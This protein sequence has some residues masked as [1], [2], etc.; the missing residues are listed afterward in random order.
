M[1]NAFKNSYNELAHIIGNSQNCSS[2]K[3]KNKKIDLSGGGDRVSAGI[4]DGAKDGVNRAFGDFQAVCSAVHQPVSTLHKHIDLYS[5]TLS[6][7]ILKNAFRDLSVSLSY[8]INTIY[9]YIYIIDYLLLFTL[10]NLCD[11]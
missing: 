9:V 1:D 10:I 5:S 4:K 7:G 3:R 11:N 2:L 6:R 8:I